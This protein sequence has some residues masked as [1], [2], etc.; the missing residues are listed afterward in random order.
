MKSLITWHL[1]E[2]AEKWLLRG[3]IKSS[4]VVTRL[5]RYDNQLHLP[6]VW[7]AVWIPQLLIIL[8]LL[9]EKCD[10]LRG[11]TKPRLYAYSSGAPMHLKYCFLRTTVFQ[12]EPSVVTLIIFTVYAT[13]SYYQWTSRSLISWV[14]V[15]MSFRAADRS[16]FKAA[17]CHSGHRHSASSHTC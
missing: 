14:H 5:P 7:L 17:L 13:A 9:Q 1:S 10:H 15:W 4:V 6:A 16:S 8:A 3:S 12:F 11:K 2:T